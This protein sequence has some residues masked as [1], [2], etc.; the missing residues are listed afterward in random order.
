MVRCRFSSS[1]LLVALMVLAAGRSH[2]NPIYRGAI[3][4][5]ADSGAV[6]FEDNAD[7]VGPPA[8]MTKLMSYLVVH[9]QIRA[10]RL[11]FAS[12]VTVT[13]ADARMGGTQVWLKEGET[14]SVEELLMATM[15]QS[16]NDAAHALARAAAGSREGF[17]AAMNARSAQLGLTRTTWR[18]PHG[19]PPTSRQ[20]EEG[21]LT[22]PRD[23]A[24]L[25]RALVR[26]TDILRFTSVS[27][28]AFGEQQRTEPVMMS[29]HN[30]LVGKVP[31]VDGLKT[32]YTR[33]AGFCLTATAARD[34]RR[35]VA[36]MM[37]SPSAKERDVKM[38]ELIETAFARLG[39]APT[40][41]ISAPEGAPVISRAPLPAPAATAPKAPAKAKDEEPTVQFKL[42]PR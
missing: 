25:A 19:L 4:V 33:A 1:L 10:G 28:A 16:A 15:I 39:P 17:L 6:L 35:L 30:R 32:G 31:G 9:D 21:D 13:A 41:T 12:P 3:V 24:G 7:Y 42:P 36:V 27:R 29:N 38:A 40:R 26:E 11:S 20:N 22:S 5:D 34:G 8:S 23:L 14:F 2:A 18:T 37:G